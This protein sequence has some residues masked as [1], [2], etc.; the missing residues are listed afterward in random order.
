MEKLAVCWFGI[1]GNIVPS[2]DLRDCSSEIALAGRYAAFQTGKWHIPGILLKKNPSRLQPRGS[3][4][5]NPI[6]SPS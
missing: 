6:S 2:I 4:S 1:Q 5:H 3:H